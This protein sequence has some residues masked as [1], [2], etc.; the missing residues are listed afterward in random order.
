MSPAASRQSAATARPANRTP[1]AEALPVPSGRSVENAENP[2]SANETSRT[3]VSAA[4]AATTAMVA[5]E[6]QAMCTGDP[7]RSGG[8]V[9]GGRPG[10]VV[11]V[12]V[13]RVDRRATR[14]GVDA[15]GQGDAAHGD[16][17]DT[18]GA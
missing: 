13:G 16:H 6:P 4:A 17:E 18:P 10:R 3:T 1:G 7:F 2:T 9:D 15:R 8:Q 14:R 11:V 5:N 12:D